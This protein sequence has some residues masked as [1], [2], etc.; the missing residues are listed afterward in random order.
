MD[1]N[2]LS[3]FVTE[4]EQFAQEFRDSLAFSARVLHHSM[5]FTHTHPQLS[6]NTTRRVAV[7]VV[8][9]ARKCWKGPNKSLL[10]L[11]IWFQTTV[12]AIAVIFSTAR[13]E[14]EPFS[15]LDVDAL[16]LPILLVSRFHS[17]S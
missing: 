10:L 14:K 13:A 2:Y 11:F 5:D 9:G 4:A 16:L 15:T 1:C 12:C 8:G 7:I 3:N 6:H 17:C